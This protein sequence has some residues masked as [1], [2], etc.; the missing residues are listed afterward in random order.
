MEAL[1]HLSDKGKEDYKLIQKALAGDEHAYADIMDRYKRPVH[2][3]LLKMFGNADDADDLTMESFAKAF[4]NLDSYQPTFAFSTWFFKIATNSAIDFL[5]KK[6]ANLI[7]IDQPFS[8]DEG[9]NY[10]AEIKSESKDPEKLT[11]LH[12]KQDI[13]HKVVNM[14]TQKYRKL[15][16]LRYFKEFSYEEISKELNIPVGT[17]KARLFRAKALLQHILLNNKDKF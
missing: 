5:R 2:Y 15:I 13:V 11:I 7:S 17:V 4:K 1:E 8:D 9:S 6:R 3:M 12:Q 14:I 10:Y 16:E